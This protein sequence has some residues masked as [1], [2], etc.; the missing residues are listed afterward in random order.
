MRPPEAPGPHTPVAF[1]PHSL[2]IAFAADG[3]IVAVVT[4]GASLW[5]IWQS[6]VRAARGARRIPQALA[7]GLSAGLVALVIDCGINTIV[8]FFALF[9]QIVPLALAVTRTDAL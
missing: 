5:I 1:D 3:G 4:L 2:P 8:L 7:Y 6:L 9:L